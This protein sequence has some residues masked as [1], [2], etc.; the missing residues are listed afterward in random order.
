MGQ[1]HWTHAAHI[2]VSAEGGQV[3]RWNVYEDLIRF[4]F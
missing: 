3:Y 1:L 4:Q 2:Y